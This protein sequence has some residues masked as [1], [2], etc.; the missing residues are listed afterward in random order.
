M[1]SSFAK[2]SKTEYG[3]SVSWDTYTLQSG[4]GRDEDGCSSVTMGKVTHSSF[5]LCKYVKVVSFHS[6]S[7]VQSQLSFRR[8]YLLLRFWLLRDIQRKL[9]HFHLELQKSCHSDSFLGWNGPNDL[10]IA[11]LFTWTLKP[12]QYKLTHSSECN[13]NLFIFFGNFQLP[14]L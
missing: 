12:T 9:S 3:R 7:D 6:A 8:T 1:V 11:Q 14:W 4:H 10:H 13:K 5:V 2:S